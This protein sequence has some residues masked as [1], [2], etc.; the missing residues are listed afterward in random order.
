MRL[1]D[2]RE[3]VYLSEATV[4]RIT[5]H[6]GVSE[7]AVREVY[8]EALED[9]AVR[10]F[11][12]DAKECKGDCCTVSTPTSGSRPTAQRRNLMGDPWIG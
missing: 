2:D 10:I 7:G 5:N 12:L 8:G 6:F 4:P 9:E 11:L 3:V 1:D